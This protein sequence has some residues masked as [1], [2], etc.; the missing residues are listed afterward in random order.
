MASELIKQ[1]TL[2]VAQLENA[3]RSER[4]Q[5]PE[6]VAEAIPDVLNHLRLHGIVLVHLG[7]G[8]AKNKRDALKSD[9]ARAAINA[10]WNLSQAPLPAA[11]IEQ[12]RLAADCGMK[13]W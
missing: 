2:R 7:E 1:L 8:F 5:A 4:A 9:A 11:I 13:R 6:H 10:A 12:V 3:L